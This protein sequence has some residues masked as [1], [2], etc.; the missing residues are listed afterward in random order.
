MFLT[1]LIIFLW[2]DQ[3]CRFNNIIFATAELHHYG[4]IIRYAAPFSVHK[5]RRFINVNNT[6]KNGHYLFKAHP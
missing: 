2:L 5:A 4:F 6:G 3:E 1:Q